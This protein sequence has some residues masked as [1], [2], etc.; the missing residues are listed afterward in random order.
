MKKI[1]GII[2]VFL[3]LSFAG[4]S[5]SLPESMPASA[6]KASA[7]DEVVLTN[8]QGIATMVVQPASISDYLDVP[9]HIQPDPT[10]VVRVFPPV[11]GRLI[12]V[13]IRPGDRV[14]KGQ[15]LATLESSE[16][17]AARAD[18]QKARADNELKQAALKRASL[19]F[20]HQ[21]LAEKDYEQAHADA[22]MAQAELA[23]ARE[24]LRLLGIDPEGSSDILKVV[25]TRAGTVLDIGAAPGELSK[26][27]DSP[28]PLCTLADLDVVWAVGDVYE[29][30]VESLKLAG[31]AR[32]RVN[33]YPGNTW[34]GP[35]RPLSDALD[36]ATRTLKVR[37]VLPNPGWRL[38]PEMFA[39]ISIPHT[40][41]QG[42]LIPAS[43]VLH[44]GDAAAV[45]VEKSAGHFQRR[46]VSLGRTFGQRVEV[47]G[48]LKSGEK[49]VVEGAL[50]LRSAAS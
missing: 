38:K 9:A 2:S 44:E 6:L 48:G 11:G 42:I 40:G 14:K 19:L 27:L 35:V 10:R 8:T 30:D 36:P 39:S 24:H 7:S 33:A 12:S 26:S 46:T 47:T 4:C 21:V 15:T 29:K 5:R 22:D 20:E 45:Y 28:A 16:V 23:R 3:A 18:Y 32:V 31:K 41:A 37:V 17:S 25:A 1:L 43:A 13:E 49:I 34:E 50:L